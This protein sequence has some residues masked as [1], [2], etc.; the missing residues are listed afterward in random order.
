MT[1]DDGIRSRSGVVACLREIDSCT[2]RLIFDDVTTD[3]PHHPVDWTTNVLYTF[4]DYNKDEMVALNLSQ[5][6]FAMI[7]ENLIAR[8]LSLEVRK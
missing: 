8:L 5:E 4:N 6:E 1:Q 2:L 7:G 3:D